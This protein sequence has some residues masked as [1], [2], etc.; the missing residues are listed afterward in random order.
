MSF[1]N[2]GW[3]GRDLPKRRPSKSERERHRRS[4]FRQLAL[5]T[6]EDR[7]VL[8]GAPLAFDEIADEIEAATQAIAAPSSTVSADLLAASIHIRGEDGFA[9]GG[10][11]NYTVQTFDVATGS[12]RATIKTQPPTSVAAGTAFSI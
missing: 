6:L 4:Q 8:S 12:S 2:G 5:E 7:R 3:F 10:V 9:D 1:A 11:S